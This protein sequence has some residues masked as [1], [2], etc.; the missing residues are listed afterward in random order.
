MPTQVKT[1]RQGKK[2]PR[3]LLKPVGKSKLGRA[4]I[5]KAVRDVLAAKDKSKA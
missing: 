5:R 3:R 2:S 4:S 1:K